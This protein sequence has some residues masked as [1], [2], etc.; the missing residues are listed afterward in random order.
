M[1]DRFITK[2]RIKPFDPTDTRRFA[3]MTIT[4]DLVRRSKP[5]TTY[6]KTPLTGAQMEVTPTVENFNGS[7]WLVLTIE[8]FPAASLAGQNFVHGDLEHI[9]A[10]VNG[11]GALIRCT[12]QKMGFTQEE[13]DF[14]FKYS[15]AEEVEVV[16]HTVTASRRAARALQARTIKHFKALHQL[17][18]RHDIAIRHVDVRDVDDKVG[19][20]ITLADKSRFR[21]YIKAEQAESRSK[22]NRMLSFVAKV[23][24]KARPALSMAIDTHVRN[25]PILTKALLAK[26]G[27][28]SPSNWTPEAF[29][30]AIHEF[31]FTARLATPYATSLNQVDLEGLSPEVQHTAVQHFAGKNLAEVLPPHT[32]TRH[33]S[34]LARRG[35]ELGIPFNTNKPILSQSLGKQLSYSARWHPPKEFLEYAVTWDTL[36]AILKA[37]AAISPVQSLP[38]DGAGE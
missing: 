12:L 28:L 27:L 19:L 32:F 26:H 33:R 7:D 13:I 4:Q 22:A 36:P 25:E 38:V 8:F 18:G 24:Q 37:I 35:V 31:M 17:T 10:E 23:L 30:A 5:I 11:S 9:E 6:I 15:E 14:F 29:E 3:Q 2:G 21:Q 16:W 20:M 1:L 34:I